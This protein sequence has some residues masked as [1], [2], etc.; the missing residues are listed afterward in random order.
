M[1]LMLPLYL[2]LVGLFLIILLLLFREIDED[3]S[4]NVFAGYVVTLVFFVP[5]CVIGTG[6]YTWLKH[7]EW[8]TI[9]PEFLLS[10]LNE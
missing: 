6:T 7:G 10:H 1:S 8:L 2:W 3:F 5:I 4:V 9:S